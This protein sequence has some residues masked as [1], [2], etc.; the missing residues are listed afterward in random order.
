M[1]YGIII[2]ASI[3]S[4]M[5]VIIVLAMWI[6]WARKKTSHQINSPDEG[7]SFIVDIKLC[8]YYQGM[9]SN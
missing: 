2:G 4:L 5:S 9:Y 6:V 1:D 8:I 7:I 3:G